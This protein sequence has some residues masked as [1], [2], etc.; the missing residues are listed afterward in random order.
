MVFRAIE[1]VGFRLSD[2]IIT[3][4]EARK[5]EVQDLG[6][7]QRKVL[8]IY[9]GPNLADF[10]P[11]V[12]RGEARARLGF[13]PSAFIVA[14]VGRLSDEKGI[15]DLVGAL[16]GREGAMILAVAGAGQ[17][18]I[19]LKAFIAENNLASQVR[20]LGQVDNISLV[21][22][23][24]DVLVSPSR[25]EG[26][27]MTILEAMSFGLP[28]VATAVGGTPELVDDSV[29]YLLPPGDM[30]AVTAALSALAANPAEL[31]QKGT[32]ARLRVR[33][34]FSL[35]NMADETRRCL[36]ALRDE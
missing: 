19:E 7:G 5:R 18:E 36:L 14:Y 21:Y 13:P 35:E 25:D 34:R 12:S 11:P 3:V 9:N 2:R 6:I 30:P 16:R 10:G 22:Q 29:G 32:N 31:A 24:A 33:S 4:C 8:V 26:L 23:A 28:V 20:L 27:S 1:H 15:G 17:L